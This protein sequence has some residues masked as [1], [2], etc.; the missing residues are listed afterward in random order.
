[1]K[2]EF[3]KHFNTA[4][5]T[6]KNQTIL[7]ALSGGA[8][9]MALLNLLK[10]TG[11]KVKAAHCNFH[12]RGSESDADEQFVRQWCES[13]EIPLLVQQF[14]TQNY[15]SEKGVSI[16]MAAR[17]LRYNWFEEILKEGFADVLATGHHRD[18][19]I[20]TF[21]LNLLRGT[22][23]KGLTGIKEV[24]DA[25]IRPMLIFSR[26]EIEAYCKHKEI[27]YVTDSSNLESVYT[28][29]KIRNQILPLFKEINPSFAQTMVHNMDV[30]NQC[31]E[32]ITDSLA[33]VKERIV[34]Y[35]EGQMLIS[36]RHIKELGNPQLFLFEM[37][38][39]LGFNGSQIEEMVS[40]IQTSASGKQ[41]FSAS[42]RLIID[43]FNVIVLPFSED[44]FEE[45]YYIEKESQEIN[46]PLNI[47]VNI[48]MDASNYIIVKDCTV[49]QFDADLLEYPLTIRKWK[50]GDQFRPLG[51]KQFKKLSDFFIDNKF[52]IKQKEDTWLLLSGDDIV[53][54]VGHRTDDRYKITPKTN[55]I[56]V[57][58]LSH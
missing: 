34:V 30:L 26:H 54:V 46:K 18:D 2:S 47:S 45:V 25:A 15:A 57:F 56:A 39:P 9:S 1:M 21:F 20:E 52:S 6:Y 42:H 27:P 49:A 51:M 35:E 36:L 4:F 3:E 13:R 23:I 41:F 24:S 53:W 55:Q 28:R 31:E 22:G 29:N 16:E 32:W 17:K 43:R 12:L 8:D 10:T 58:T 14:D 44:E 50:Q 33:K 11:I 48:V 38:H 37:L 7:V 40:C 19:S 5:N